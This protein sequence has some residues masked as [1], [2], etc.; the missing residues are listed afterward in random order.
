[1][2]SSKEVV[3]VSSSKDS[4]SIFNLEKGE[5]YLTLFRAYGRLEIHRFPDSD[6][7][8]VYKSYPKDIRKKNNDLKLSYFHVNN[9]FQVYH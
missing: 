1:M 5:E 3:Y 4:I 6:L 9:I 2:I 7:Y 8:C